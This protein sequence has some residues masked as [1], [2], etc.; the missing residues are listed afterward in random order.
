MSD[1]VLVTGATGKTGRSLVTQLR[2]AGI[3][4]RAASRNGELPFDRTPPDTWERAPLAGL[5]GSDRD[6]RL[7]GVLRP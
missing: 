3:A 4:V 6:P 2:Q 7:V 1:L 5:D